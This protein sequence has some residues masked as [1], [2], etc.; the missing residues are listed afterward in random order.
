MLRLRV[1]SSLS[2]LATAAISARR[3]PRST[4]SSTR[5]ALMFSLADWPFALADGGKQGREIRYNQG[6]GNDRIRLSSLTFSLLGGVEPEAAGG[7]GGGLLEPGGDHGGTPELS[8]QQ[9]T[10][11]VQPTQSHNCPGGGGTSFYSCDFKCCLCLINAINFCMYGGGNE[12]L[13]RLQRV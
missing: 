10:Q 5:A 8:Q 2:A 4:M 1:K 9:R 13:S 12:A 3:A 6:F 7:E 11:Q